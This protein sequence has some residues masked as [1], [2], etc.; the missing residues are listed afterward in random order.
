VPNRPEDKFGASVIY[1]RFSNAVRSYDRDLALF[2][3][4]P[5]PIRDFEA[6]LEFTYS[7]EIAS[8]W[9]I[10]PTLVRIWHPNGIAGR[11]ATV[12]GVRSLVR[13]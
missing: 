9:N 7:A 1:S 3:G 10:Q 2:T 11:D 6:N 12:F 5:N 8:G 13:Y 4:I